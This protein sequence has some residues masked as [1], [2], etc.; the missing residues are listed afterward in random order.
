MLQ[1]IEDDHE[2]K[3]KKLNKELANHKILLEE[4]HKENSYRLEESNR[5]I[6][7]VKN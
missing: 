3:I 5:S 2:L 1:D 4:A 6:T 7:N